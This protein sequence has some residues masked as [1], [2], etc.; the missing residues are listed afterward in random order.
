MLPPSLLTL[1]GKHDS[2]LHKTALGIT[3][4]D[5]S[6]PVLDQYQ[7]AS[8]CYWIA[9][10]CLK[11]NDPKRASSFLQFLCTQQYLLAVV[12]RQP[13]SQLQAQQTC[14]GEPLLAGDN[15]VGC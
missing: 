9:T 3:D 14:S 2:G 11:T 1:M 12:I 6:A 10:Y 7:A 13:V 8:A 5:P 15:A 4:I